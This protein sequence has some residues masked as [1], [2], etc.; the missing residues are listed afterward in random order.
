MP[1]FTLVKCLDISQHEFVELV[2]IDIRQDRTDDTA[3]WS[4]DIGV[5]VFPLFQVT[6][7]QEFSYQSQKPLIVDAF[8]KNAY[9]NIMVDVVKESLDVTLYEPSCSRTSLLQG[10]HSS[11]T[12]SVWSK[13][14]RAILKV[15]LVNCFE[16]HSYYFLNEL[17]L[18]RR[19]TQ[20]TKFSILFGYVYSSCRTR[21]IAFIL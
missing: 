11:M 19:D 10:S 5:F 21:T 17:V 7:F 20:R 16:Y 13:T 6:R 18:E 1:C 14:M 3:L 15:S 9:E 2:Q 4:A 8:T 12:P